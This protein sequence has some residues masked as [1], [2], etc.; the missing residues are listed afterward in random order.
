MS[1]FF[2]LLFGESGLLIVALY[3]TEQEASVFRRFAKHLPRGSLNR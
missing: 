2:F 1:N 3:V